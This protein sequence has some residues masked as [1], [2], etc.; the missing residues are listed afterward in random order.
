[1]WWFALVLILSMLAA[2]PFAHA[3]CD[4][5]EAQV[6]SD[7]RCLRPKDTFRDCV[8]CPEMVV[9]PAGSFIMG[10]PASEEARLDNEEPQR[11][12]IIARP[13]AV[14]RFEVT[15]A[16]WDACV[17]AGGCMHRL[18]TPAGAAEGVR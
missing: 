12:V 18:T 2:A 4:G 8:G 10:S 9:V 13:F 5:V 16:E 15:F 17:V 14:G 7:M 3:G 1:M 11:N 6:G